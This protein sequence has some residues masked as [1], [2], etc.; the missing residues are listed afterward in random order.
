MLFFFLLQGFFKN[1]LIP[2]K[3]KREGKIHVIYFCFKSLA[4]PKLVLVRAILWGG[5]TK[6]QPFPLLMILPCQF[7]KLV[8]CILQNIAL[9]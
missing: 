8:D 9:S 1:E 3:G 6:R 7:R 4:C 5:D 2:A